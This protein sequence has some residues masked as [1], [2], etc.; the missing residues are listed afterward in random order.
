MWANIWNIFEN[1]YSFKQLDS[2]SMRIQ[3]L[4]ADNQNK[5][6]QEQGC[7]ESFLTYLVAYGKVTMSL[8]NQIFHIFKK[9]YNLPG[10]RQKR[11]VDKDQK[12]K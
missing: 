5:V 11:S 8:P 1:L 3:I 6:Y 7:L 12:R 4:K 10:C 2:F 9:L